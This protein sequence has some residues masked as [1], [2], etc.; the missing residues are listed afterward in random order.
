MSAL[1]LVIY[2]CLKIYLHE[3]FHLCHFSKKITT[4]EKY[5][6][7]ENSDLSDSDYIELCKLLFEKK[8]VMLHTVKMSETFLPYVRLDWN[9]KLSCKEKGPTKIPIH[10]RGKLNDFLDDR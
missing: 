10:Y 2:K 5:S 9:L 7:F 6:L 3:Y 1:L 4:S 8:T